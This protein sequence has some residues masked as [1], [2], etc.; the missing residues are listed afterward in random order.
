[1]KTSSGWLVPDFH[2]FSWEFSCW[3]IICT[4]CMQ[5]PQKDIFCLFEEFFGLDL[6]CMLFNIPV[7]DERP[8]TSRKKQ[9]ICK[10]NFWFQLKRKNLNAIRLKKVIS[11]YYKRQIWLIFLYTIPAEDLESEADLQET[12]TPSSSN[13]GKKETKAHTQVSG[14]Y[15][16]RMRTHYEVVHLCVLSV[17]KRLYYMQNSLAN[18]VNQMKEEPITTQKLDCGRCPTESVMQSAGKYGTAPSTKWKNV[19]N[20]RWNIQLFKH[21][22]TLKFKIHFIEVSLQ[23]QSDFA[24][25]SCCSS[26]HYVLAVLLLL[27]C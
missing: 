12:T 21:G 9:V 13:A 19:L 6:P 27:G 2:P 14:K 15:N 7:S 8:G 1:M 22:K 10:L 17:F 26:L 25:Q 16:L 18:H 11:W 5:I 23:S 24:K 20:A 3:C 4:S